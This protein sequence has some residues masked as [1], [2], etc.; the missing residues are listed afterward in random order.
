MPGE[1]ALLAGMQQRQLHLHRPAQ[2][3]PA[4]GTGDGASR[5]G[6]AGVTR[7]SALNMGGAAIPVAFKA[8]GPYQQRGHFAERLEKMFAHFLRS[9]L[10][11]LESEAFFANPAARY[12]RLPEFLCLCPFEPANLGRHNPRP[13]A[14]WQR[15]PRAC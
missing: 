13:G 3:P 4:A 5:A 9:Q 6:L 7:G 15:K 10:Y 1:H 8:S 12:P 14:R 11:I 2:G